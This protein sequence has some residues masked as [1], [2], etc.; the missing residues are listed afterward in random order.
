MTTTAR[1]TQEA[2]DKGS[3]ASRK[4][5][6]VARPYWRDTLGR[7]LRHVNPRKRVRQ[8]KRGGANGSCFYID[9]AFLDERDFEE[10]VRAFVTYLENSGVWPYPELPVTMKENLDSKYPVMMLDLDYLVQID[11][12]AYKEVRAVVKESRLQPKLVAA[13]GEGFKPVKPKADSVNLSGERS[14]KGQAA[15]HLKLPVNEIA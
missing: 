9:Y 11:D 4:L 12:P 10:Q 5:M 3:A 8:G 13:P 6:R 2:L 7:E 1:V 15:K 14:F